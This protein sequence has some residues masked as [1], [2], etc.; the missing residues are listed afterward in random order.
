M[1]RSVGARL[2]R[3]ADG[4]REDGAEVVVIEPTAEDLHAMGVN[5]M[6]VDRSRRIVETAA[7]SVG[8]RLPAGLDRLGL[9]DPRAPARRAEPIPALAA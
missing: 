8:A 9:S 6:G 7:A 1:R 4:L 5:P 2:G 3:E